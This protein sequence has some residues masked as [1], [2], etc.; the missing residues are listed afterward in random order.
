M[1]HRHAARGGCAPVLGPQ[2]LFDGDGRESKRKRPQHPRGTNM[3]S[4]QTAVYSRIHALCTVHYC[5]EKH[6]GRKD[7]VPFTDG[8]F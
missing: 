2:S 1:S 7:F 3:S 5:C 8:H 4:V 6:V